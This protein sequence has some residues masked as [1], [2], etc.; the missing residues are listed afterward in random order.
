MKLGDKVNFNFAKGKK[1]E[2]K[3]VVENANLPISWEW[4]R[5]NCPHCSKKISSVKDYTIDIVNVLEEDNGDIIYIGYTK[6]LI[7]GVPLTMRL[8]DNSFHKDK[9]MSETIKN[10]SKFLKEKKNGNIISN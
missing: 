10:K 6:E 3:E 1:F 7:N 4:N 9:D 2:V 8:P 5:G